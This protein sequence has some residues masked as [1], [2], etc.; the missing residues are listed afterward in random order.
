M[1]R[2]YKFW[3]RKE[4]T[5]KDLSEALKKSKTEKMQFDSVVEVDNEAPRQ[6][7]PLVG[8]VCDTESDYE[9]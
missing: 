2:K 5:A 1:L 9:T 4:V 7:E 3:Y 6:L 8:F